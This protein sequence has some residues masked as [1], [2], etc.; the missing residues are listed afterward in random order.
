MVFK[1]SLGSKSR[2][3]V[4]SMAIIMTMWAN[5]ATAG[6][7]DVLI[8]AAEQGDINTLKSII[9]DGADV[10]AT[11]DDGMTS[12][13]YA[14]MGGHLEIVRALIAKGADVNAK[15]NDGVSSLMYASL[16]GHLEI[17]R[18]L[19]AKGAEVN[20]RKNDGW[21]VLMVASKGGH[22]EV[23]QTLLAQGA[24]VNAES[25]Y[26]WT[27]LSIA[28]INA[29]QRVVELL[30]EAGAQVKSLTHSAKAVEVALQPVPAVPS[31][32]SVSPLS[33]PEQTTAV[34]VELGPAGHAEGGNI[35][36][37]AAGIPLPIAIPVI[38]PNVEPVVTSVA[39]I[40]PVISEP[41][42]TDAPPSTPQA[43][44]TEAKKLE[45]KRV[46]YTLSAGE[47]I[48]RSKLGI[49]IKK[50]KASG[51]KP[52]V[53]EESK[54]TDV[55]RLVTECFNAGSTAQKRLANL[56]RKEKQAFIV[57]DGEQYCVAAASYFSYDAARTEQDIFAKNGLATE[58]VKAQVTLTIWQIT[59][60]RYND[61]PSAVAEQKRLA[62]RGID[63][64]LISLDK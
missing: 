24:E 52:V 18:A 22:L 12:L 49:L 51:L 62:E 31:R 6:L 17:V 43:P 26:G 11:M 19:I 47:I 5:I 28:S 55:Y 29:H 3:I 37:P 63:A 8:K 50:L 53:R 10:N 20:A 4:I 35:S 44:K 7:N 36:P 46:S 15:T 30:K 58:I 21:T 54:T 23:V 41:A 40:K 42:Q 33:R 61:R 48:N 25:R 59:A 27:A 34:R 38:P 2:A 1:T 13:M 57:H 39:P 45:Q 64:V 9:H 14:S 60:G 16:G 32:D 56:A